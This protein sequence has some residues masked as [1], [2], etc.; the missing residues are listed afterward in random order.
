MLTLGN[1]PLSMHPPQRVNYRLD[2]PAHKLM[3]TPFPRRVRAILGGET[4]L[5]TRDGQLLYESALLPQLYVPEVDIRLDLMHPTDHTTHCPFK[6]DA[7]Y[8]TIRVGD[9]AADNAVWG[10]PQPNPAAT[11]L[12]GYRA[13]YWDRLDAWFDEDEEV[14]GHLRDP[15]TRVDVVASSRHIRVLAGDRVIVETSAPKVLSETGLPNR[16]YLPRDAVGADLL[17]RSD[18][19]MYC[20]YKGRSTY[21]SLRVGDELIPDVAW[22]YE[23]PLR[24]A[25][26]VAGHLCFL[27]DRLV[28]EADGSPPA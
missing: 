3:M 9:R 12:A 21:W 4:V 27:H 1:G 26:D 16:Y 20:P 8:W 14:F 22:S 6:G 19:S 10:Y 7:S 15:Y 24:D 5:D 18:T 17:E 13:F 28:I 25:G 23:Q 11:W 2:G